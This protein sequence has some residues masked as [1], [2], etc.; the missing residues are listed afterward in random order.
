MYKTHILHQQIRDCHINF[1]HKTQYFLPHLDN[2]SQLGCTFVWVL[3]LIACDYAYS[4]ICDMIIWHIEIGGCKTWV[5][6][7]VIIEFNLNIYCV[8]LYCL[9]KKI[10]LCFIDKCNNVFKFN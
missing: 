9:K 4:L 6:H 7:H 10:T 3:K 8:E 5:L 1:L 2:N